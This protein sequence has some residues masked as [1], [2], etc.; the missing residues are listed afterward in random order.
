MSDEQTRAW[1]PE[2]LTPL[3]EATHGAE[4]VWQELGR[5]YW[6]WV[7]FKTD[8]DNWHAGGIA[9]TSSWVEPSQDLAAEFDEP[10]QRL[11]VF[12]AAG[13]T[14]TLPQVLCEVCAQP[15]LLRSRQAL[16]AVAAGRRPQDSCG[17]CNQG[18]QLAV[19]R[20]TEPG[21]AARRA[22]K[23]DD[24]DQRRRQHETRQ[25]RA[26]LQTVWKQ[27]CQ[28]AL[29]KTHPVQFLGL[30]PEDP[31]PDQDHSLREE[32]CTLALL[33]YAPE[34]ASPVP[35]VDSWALAP[36]SI[37]HDVL[38][39]IWG[40]ELVRIH[41]SSSVDAFVWSPTFD[42]AAE[43]A[44]GDPAKLPWPS[45]DRLW[46]GRVSWFARQGSSLGTSPRVLETH[47]KQRAQAWLRTQVGQDDARAV[48]LEVMVAEALRYFE[49]QL[50]EHRLPSVAANHE[51]RLAEAMR[52]AA[53]HLTL[54]QMYN[55]AWRAVR[56][57]AAAAQSKPRAPLENMTTHGVNRFETSVR[58]F[59]TSDRELVSFREVHQM[60][61]T[62]LTR[63]VF[64]TLLDL[65]P[66]RTSVED[67]AQTFPAVEAWSLPA[68]RHDGD[69]EAPEEEAESS[70][71]TDRLAQWLSQVQFWVSEDGEQEAST[72]P[73]ALE[74]GAVA[75]QLWV[76]D[77][78][79][80]DRPTIIDACERLA[81]FHGA[82]QGAG[83]SARSLFLATVSAAIIYPGT[84]RTGEAN[85][86]VPLADVLL[87][88]ITAAA[89]AARRPGADEEPPF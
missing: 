71:A 53:V 24:Q 45:A 28:E 73:A 20:V 33:E 59:T 16:D 79:V 38:R 19:A 51:E 69:G 14:A 23:R 10:A 81:L 39:T 52:R 2:R 77:V 47:L 4:Q 40:A 62:G 27:L 21:A 43:A 8:P 46:L 1:R 80:D 13:V 26:A 72:I 15:V 89:A 87:R 61:L 88:M 29:A 50:Q 32:L 70:P 76:Q 9:P 34:H 75:Q 12:A 17:R 82:L 85:V 42:E 36:A 66:M 41:P 67:A 11:Y 3:I 55:L 83:Q 86:Q 68:G 74:P 64:G 5:R 6:D 35:P 22:R 25:A 54:G 63:T 49:D 56:D 30:K 65:D 60:P 84:I 57:A 48:L 7:G 37:Q 31:W 58:D 78:A 44:A 18:M